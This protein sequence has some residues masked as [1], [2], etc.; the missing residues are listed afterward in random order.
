[1]GQGFEDQGFAAGAAAALLD[2]V[3]RRQEKCGGV[4]RQRLAVSAAAAGVK[5]VGRVEDE[6]ALRDV[7]CLRPSGPGL[8][9]D[10]STVLDPAGSFVLAWRRLVTLPAEALLSTGNLAASI[11]D[12]GLA[13]AEAI[14]ADITG[15]LQRIAASSN[16]VFAMVGE[17]LELLQTVAL[18]MERDFWPWLADA[19]T[20][21]AFN[22][23]RAVPLFGAQPG[24]RRS[25]LA[26][27]ETF[28]QPC[29]AASFGPLCR[30]ST[31]RP[32]LAAV[33]TGCSLSRRDC[34]PRGPISSSKT[35]VRR[36]ACR[37]PTDRRHERPRG[38]RRLF[39][40]LVELGAVR[41]LSGRS[42]FRMYGL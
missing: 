23:P 39:E 26:G 35:A 15:E 17:A 34:G 1:V 32:S 6:A 42:T 36:C 21:N 16:P 40:R 38:L 4:W 2:R 5:R 31:C 10:G 25:R 33:L 9:V 7:W 19:M 22:W 27:R 41:E 24:G 37:L 29:L 8:L 30:P 11:G 3:V 20:A 12:F 28:R 14:A 18:G 13:D